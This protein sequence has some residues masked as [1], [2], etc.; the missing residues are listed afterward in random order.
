MPAANKRF[1]AS[2]GVFSADSG[3]VTS[4]FALVR[5]FTDTPA[6][7][8]PQVVRR[9]TQT[10]TKAKRNLGTNKLNSEWKNITNSIFKKNEV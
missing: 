1:G 9:N 10:T 7:V 6:S 2:G 3:W 8:K 4:S 5:A